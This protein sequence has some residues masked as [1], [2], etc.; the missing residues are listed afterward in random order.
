MLA[1]QRSAS[2]RDFTGRDRRAAWGGAM[3][4]GGGWGARGP[5]PL[6]LKGEGE[7]GSKF[8]RLP[9]SPFREREGWGG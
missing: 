3:A 6:S 7:I 5:G 2:V 1:L 4:E 9:P 8:E